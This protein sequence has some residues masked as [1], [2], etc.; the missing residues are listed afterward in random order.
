MKRIWLA[1]VAA[2]V[3]LTCLPEDSFARGGF[4]GGGFGGG[5]HGGGFGGG[6]RGAAVGG[7]FRGA[8]IG[9]GFRGAAI[10]GGFRGARIGGFRGPIGGGFRTATLGGFRGPIGGF[11][12][13]AFRARS[14]FAVQPSGG[15]A[16]WSR[17]VSDS[18][19]AGTGV[20]PTAIP[21]TT[22]ASFGPGMAG[23]TSATE[24]I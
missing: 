21:T 3:L 13:R 20:T 12:G 22:L 4:H 9:G 1:A 23:P 11:R 10:G 6:F 24:R 18:A 5:F 15:G 7:G 2:L 17:R 8:A 16:G 14:P 19:R